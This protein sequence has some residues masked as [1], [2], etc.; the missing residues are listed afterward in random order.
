MPFYFDVQLRTYDE[1][2]PGAGSPRTA[3]RI[4]P[5]RMA[6]LVDAKWVDICEN[7]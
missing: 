4:P 6:D 5:T 2:V 1:V 7:R 3:L